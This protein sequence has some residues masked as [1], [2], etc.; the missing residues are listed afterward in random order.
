MIYSLDDLTIDTVRK[1]VWRSQQN[2]NV[3]GLNFQF[4]SFLLTQETQ[5]VTF[6]ELI[7]GVWSP[8][9][10][11]EDTVIQRVR[12]LRGVLGDNPHD[13]RYIRSVRGRGYQL[14]AH[15]I[16][17]NVA[18]KK[19]SKQSEHSH[20][21][22]W[23]ASGVVLA[24]LLFSSSLLVLNNNTSFYNNTAFDEP[25]LL[26]QAHNRDSTNKFLERA[27]YYASIGQ[28]ENTARAIEL[29]QRVLTD[30]PKN[31]HAM[32]GLS[33][34]YTISMC[35]FNAHRSR[36]K[37]A[38]ILARKVIA[39]EPNNFE[40]YRVL[41]FSHDCRGQALEAKNAYLQAIEIDPNHDVKSQSA[42]AYLLGEK[43]ELAK[44]LA[45][46]LFVSHTDPE[47]TFS[48]IQ[49]ARI[50][51]LLGLHVKAEALYAESFDLYPDN[52]FSNLSYPR[53]LFHQG[54]FETARKILSKAKT[55][56][57]HPDLWVLSAE[58]ALLDNND[59]QAKQDLQ[60]AAALRPSA[61]Y[62]D[63]LV[64]LYPTL[65]QSNDWMSEKLAVL[66]SSPKS[67]D[68]EDWLKHA[69]LHQA[70][71]EN[72][73]AVDALLS[74]VESGYRNRDYLTLSPFF[75]SL[76]SHPRFDDVIKRINLAVEHELANVH[77]SGLLKRKV[78][79]S[80]VKP[81]NSTQ[82]KYTQA[83]IPAES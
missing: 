57:A 16:T 60:T 80:D 64:Q 38:E 54:K 26:R 4:L 21:K 56:P 20:S 59:E 61:Q 66:K 40:A 25:S 22:I 18:L 1:K 37:Q 78:R 47:Q 48:L 55:R 30:E 11:T 82:A 19:N 32:I 14:V 45:I 3:S 75:K 79:L 50:Y 29:F 8:A 33:R 23:L 46:N 63:M 65:E 7:A 2:L 41:G 62:L 81:F 17:N 43:G 73:A 35:R 9:V 53:N 77:A 69:L 68:P 31:T 76:R 13:P 74:A 36:A 24:S 72:Q 44:A 51:E 58:L 39:I 12:L 15:P 27:E 67:S 28:K 5:V 10:V 34:A 49:L 71:G 42:L 83:Q 6:E 70:L 52:I